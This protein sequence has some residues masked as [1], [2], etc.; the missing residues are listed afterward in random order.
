MTY[1]ILCLL[2]WKTFAKNS[3]IISYKVSGGSKGAPP[4]RP[5][6]AQNL[7]NFMQFFGK[8]WQNRRLAPPSGGLAPPPMGKPGS[9]PEGRSN[10]AIHKAAGLMVPSCSIILPGT[11]PETPISREWSWQLERPLTVVPT[12]KNAWP[13]AL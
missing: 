9:A 5:P 4:G 8:F 6:T 2:M 7:V 3:E 1:S 13:V 10:S 12:V 11:I